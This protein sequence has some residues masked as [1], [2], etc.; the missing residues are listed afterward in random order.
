MALNGQPQQLTTDAR[1]NNY[2]SI[3]ADGRYIVFSSSRTRRDQIWRMDA[4]GSNSTQL[5][6][7]GGFRVACSPDGQWVVY[8][9]DVDG[10][11]TLWR[12]PIQGGNPE[13]LTKVQSSNPALSPDGQMLAYKDNTISERSRVVIIPSGG[14]PE[15]KSF[16]IQVGN[17]K[18]HWTPDGRNLAYVDFLSEN[19]EIKLQ[20][21][22]GGQPQTLLRVPGDQIFNF[23]F[24]PDGK[25]LAYSSGRATTDLV[26]LAEAE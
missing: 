9:N 26:T 24:S 20:P 18:I 5:T 23:A 3:S 14:G 19:H 1:A 2:P 8:E 10:M 21:L 6:T 22:A 12:I 4:D 15:I 25:S 13:Q 11:W 17:G 16:D 7:Q